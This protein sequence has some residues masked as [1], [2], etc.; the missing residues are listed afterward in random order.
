V[1]K[2]QPSKNTCNRILASRSWGRQA[3]LSS[4][5]EP[6]DLAAVAFG[7]FRH[8]QEAFDL[9]HG[10]QLR[11]EFEAQ[12]AAGVGFAIERLGYGCRAAHLA[13]G[14]NF[15]LKFAAFVFDFEHV[16]DTNI[17]GGLGEVAVGLDAAH[18]AGFL[19]KRACFEE[20]RGPQPFVDANRGVPG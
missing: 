19:G 2:F 7:G 20:A 14:E 5:A 11:C 9:L 18:L 8:R 3:K 10:F 13:Q 4:S 12:L 1:L 6:I 17:A 16:A 15:N